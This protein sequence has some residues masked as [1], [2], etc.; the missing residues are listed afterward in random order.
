MA[1]GARSLQWWHIT[2]TGATLSASRS[3]FSTVGHLRLETKQRR[4]F[5]ITNVPGHYETAEELFA[6]PCTAKDSE[7]VVGYDDYD[8]EQERSWETVCTLANGYMGV[9]GSAEESAD[10]PR[11][12]PGTYLA[13]GYNRSVSRA[14]GRR[15]ALA[16]LVNWPNWLP[17]QIRTRGGAWLSPDSAD[18]LRYEKRLDVSR[19]ILLRAMR[20]RD[21]QG[22]ETSILS[23]RIVSMAKPHLACLRWSVVP[24]GWSGAVEIRSA[25]EGDVEN[26]GVA[27]YERFR[28]RHVEVTATGH[29]QNMLWLESRARQSLLHVALA[30]R[31]RVMLDGRPAT[32]Q[33]RFSRGETHVEERLELECTPGAV[34]NVE[35]V[36]AVYS[37]RDTTASHPLA[38]ARCAARA[39]PPADDL[40]REHEKAW[41]LI[42]RRCRIDVQS[43]ETMQRTLSLNVFHL[44]QTLSPHMVQLDVGAPARGLHGE[45][46]FGHIFWDQIFVMPFLSLRMPEIPR[47]LLMYRYRR[48]DAARQRAREAG[49]RGAMFPWRSAADGREETPLLQLNPHT[50]QWS[51]DYTHL[52]RHISAAVAYNVWQVYRAA[53]DLTFLERYGAELFIDVCRFWASIVQHDLETDR[54]HIRGVVGPDEFHTAYPDAEQP[55]IDDN[56]YTNVMAAWCLRT[57]PRVLDLI[58]RHRR[59]ELLDE[60]EVDGAAIEQWQ[61]I[62]ARMFVPFHEGEIISQFR[63]YEQLQELDWDA[64][65]ETYGSI[66]RIDHIL[67]AEGDSVFRYKASRQPDVLMLFYLLP[68][69]VLRSLLADAGYRLDQQM[70]V[71]NVEYYSRRT[72]HGSSLSDVVHAWIGLR[73]RGENAWRRFE[74]TAKLDLP[75]ESTGS[76]EGGI[77]LAAM[78]GTLDLVQR[79]LLGAEPDLDVLRFDPCELP[80]DVEV[81][82]PL[83]YCGRWIDVRR[84]HDRLEVSVRDGQ[85]GTVRICFRDELYVLGPGASKTFQLGSVRK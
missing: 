34:L 65:R 71:R 55:G 51:E 52:Q 76:L 12:Y 30:G 53:H 69:E 67:E 66:R 25:L 59:D 9:R 60:L 47:S 54:Y 78:G 29:D 77:H 11:H 4:G 75:R 73:W 19:G 15:F 37:S 21:P 46:Y 3:R 85:T 63:G 1:S 40:R 81:G 50:G 6:R 13:G 79:C 80:P 74:A 18:V 10:Q 36:V 24:H 38:A 72:S 23:W 41:A 7:L 49:F 31:T 82:A 39:A 28:N 42:W 62:A 56:A 32:H 26:H 22:R 68:F 43:D 45:E 14:A 61:Q 2:C 17:L 16:Q 64:Y 84:A 20:L 48:L 33:R 70:V 83:L 58:S 5:A 35:K 57:A 44:I 8:P 27:R